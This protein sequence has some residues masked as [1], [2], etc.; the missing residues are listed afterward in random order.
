MSPKQK[1]IGQYDKV[2]FFCP[3]SS[4]CKNLRESN[5]F[6]HIFDHKFLVMGGQSFMT[7]AK[8]LEN[9]LHK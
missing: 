3:T 6:A 8:K 9:L 4:F 5:L 1:V 7:S 2:F